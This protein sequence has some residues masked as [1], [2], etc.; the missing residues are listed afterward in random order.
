MK[1]YA[2]RSVYLDGPI[3]L[4]ITLSFLSF[5]FPFLLL[6]LIQTL[7]NLIFL[8]TQ[9]IITTLHSIVIGVRA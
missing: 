9:E 1:R 4:C 8:E 7:S 6:K 5:F 2:L 3:I